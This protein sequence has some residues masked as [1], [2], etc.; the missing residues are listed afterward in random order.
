MVEYML[1]SVKIAN[2]DFDDLEYQ[3][4]NLSLSGML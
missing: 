4:F 1:D 3:L 2:I